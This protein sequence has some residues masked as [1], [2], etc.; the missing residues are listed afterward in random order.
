MFSLVAAAA[1]SLSLC[2]YDGPA[3]VVGRAYRPDTGELVYCEFFLPTKDQ[4][5]RVL[6]Y[7]AAG[8][9]IAEKDLSG[10]AGSGSAGTA[11]PG[12]TQQD[13]RTG[14]RREVSRQGDHWL[15]RYRKS[16]TADWKVAQVPAREIDVIDA[17][18]DAYVRANW[19]QLVAGQVVTFR[20]AS[21]PHGRSIELRARRV[22]CTASAT[23]STSG[24]APP[25]CLHIDLAQALLRLFAGDLSLVY[26]LEARRLR[27][28]EGVVNLLDARGKAQRLRILY[29][30]N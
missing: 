2:D 28:F 21:P 20:F 17:G 16:S 30:Y 12:V 29:Q 10:P 8:R 14:E 11:I 6:Y 4:Q 19:Q 24:A 25:L 23:P 18:F 15:L 22:D 5:T 1:L 27:Q 26:D 7:S 3:Q 13:F 9:R